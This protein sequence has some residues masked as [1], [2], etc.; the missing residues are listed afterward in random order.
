VF[1]IA[2][3]AVDILDA[4]DSPCAVVH[5]VQGPAPFSIVSECDLEN[6]LIA[7]R[8]A[9][10]EGFFSPLFCVTAVEVASGGGVESH[11]VSRE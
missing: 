10:R 11:T 4:G 1:S 5:N 6:G 8:V 3:L 2:A 9:R 7:V